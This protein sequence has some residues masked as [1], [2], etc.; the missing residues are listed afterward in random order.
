[1]ISPK[2]RIMDVT[3]GLFA[4]QGYNSTGINQIISE[5]KVAKAS[6]YQHFK[7]KEDLC[8]AFLNARHT[9][10]FNELNNFITD[11]KDTKSKILSSFDYL[12]YMNSKENFR[13]CSFLNILSEI[14]S[15]NRKILNVIQDHKKDLRKFFSNFIKDEVLSDHIYMLFE[16]SLIESQMFKSNEMIEKSKIIISGLI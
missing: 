9:Y 13:G 11:K 6:F 7:S 3:F 8:V 15:D 10:W 2:E 14:P 5:A 1:M 12:I 16:S 4:N